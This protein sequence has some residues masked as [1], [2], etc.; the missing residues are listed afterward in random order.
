MKRRRTSRVVAYHSSD[1]TD[2]SR[3][4][5]GR[6]KGP[7][8]SGRFVEISIEQAW[9]HK[10]MR[11]AEF[12][13]LVHVASHVDND[14]VI[15]RATRDTRSSC[16]RRHRE[17]AISFLGGRNPSHELLHVIGVERINH[18][19]RAQL[20]ATRC[21]YI[22]GGPRDRAAKPTLNL[23]NEGISA[24]TGFASKVHKSFA[25]RIKP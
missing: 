24:M 8:F 22:A 18:A 20:I 23:L 12:A 5:I 11:G 16:P 17:R 19:R 2:V 14:G 6:Q 4:R 25:A 1:T 7:L 10:S 13:D 21:F 9:L 15:E 3:C